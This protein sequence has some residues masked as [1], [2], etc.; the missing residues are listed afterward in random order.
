MT[1]VAAGLNLRPHPRP[2]VSSRPLGGRAGGVRMDCRRFSI[3]TVIGA[4]I[5][6]S[7]LCWLGVTIGDQTGKDEGEAEG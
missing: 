5:W 1:A 2:P 3:F 7:V 6:C 4:A